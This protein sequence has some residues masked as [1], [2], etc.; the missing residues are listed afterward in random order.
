MGDSEAIG[1][2]ARRRRATFAAGRGA[3]LQPVNGKSTAACATSGAADHGSDNGVEKTRELSLEP[4]QSQSKSE[5]KKR[6]NDFG[7]RMR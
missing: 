5:R 4:G 2:Y 1:A 7:D 6:R 3:T